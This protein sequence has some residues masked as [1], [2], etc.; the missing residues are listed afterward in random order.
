ME[1]KEINKSE[2]TLTKDTMSRTTF[3][4]S[5]IFL[6]SFSFPGDCRMRFSD[7]PSV[8]FCFFWLF[9]WI[10]LLS[11]SFFTVV[12]WFLPYA[13]QFLL[14]EIHLP[15]HWAIQTKTIEKFLRWNNFWKFVQTS[16]IYCW[17]WYLCWKN[18][19]VWKKFT[20]FN[21]WAKFVMI[22]Y[23]LFTL[24]LFRKG[25]TQKDVSLS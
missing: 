16:M 2:S 4:S 7:A 13:Y 9:V 5:R 21:L 3:P 11:N 14:L 23:Y 25:M 15:V 17:N 20:D 22:I 12:F 6:L 10:S 24:S 19:V 8:N 1:S 18:F